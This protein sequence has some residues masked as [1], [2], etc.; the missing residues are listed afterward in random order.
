MNDS[1]EFKK[2]DALR[3]PPTPHPLSPGVSLRYLLTAQADGADLTCALVHIPAG[4]EPMPHIHE[5]SDDL[6]YVLEGRGRLEVEGHGTTPLLPGIFA[7]VPR[8]RIHT[9]CN[10]DQDLLLF[11]VWSPATR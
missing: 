11:N 3:V 8:G 10:I 7:R 2:V 4:S 1:G 6:I 9:P 5:A